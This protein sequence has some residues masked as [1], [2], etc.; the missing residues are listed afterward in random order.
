MT[1]ENVVEIFKDVPG[2]VAQGAWE[3]LLL[4][5]S[6]HLR[7]I[8]LLIFVL[9]FATTMK[10]MMGRWGSLGSLLYNFFYFGILFII[11]LFWGPEI[12]IND[13]FGFACA[14][15]LYPICYFAAGVV[16]DRFR[17]A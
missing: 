5:L 15:V 8:L 7:A 9:F 12:F 4:I 10:A 3:Y 6:N 11:G 1:P 14:V 2:Q 16:L 17:R 13:Y